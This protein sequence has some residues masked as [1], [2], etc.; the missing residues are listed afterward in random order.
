MLVWPG[1]CLAVEIQRVTPNP[2][3]I[4]AG[5][6]QA[7]LIIQGTELTALREVRS[8]ING[9]VTDHVI[10]RPAPEQGGMREFVLLARP[11]APRG[12]VE[13]V[14]VVVGGIIPL[15]VQAE[16]VEPGDTRAVGSKKAA[17]ISQAA[18]AGRG[19]PIIVDR[20][21]VPVVEKTRPSPLRVASDGKP[22]TLVLA[23]KNL[24]R[25]TDVRIRREEETAR[26]R[27]KQGRLPFRFRDG[28]LE[29]DVVASH[30]T[31]LGTRYAL[32]LLVEDYRSASVILEVGVP[33]PE[34][35]PAETPPEP[36]VRQPRVIELPTMP[37][38]AP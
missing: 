27:G 36:E 38:A 28:V 17:D 26:Y 15:P 31:P 18:R 3:F 6:G 37:P 4:E 7:W 9:K 12:R 21:Q 1:G 8:R 22:V 24:D 29:V 19:Q 13:L 33:L 11:D 14:A 2:I 10:G 35:I 16:V 34:E 25:V 20:N 5:G 32:D 23:G 30:K